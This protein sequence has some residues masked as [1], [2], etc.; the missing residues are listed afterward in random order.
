MSMR[1]EARCDV[2]IDT[3]R[4]SGNEGGGNEEGGSQK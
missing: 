2:G 4:S 1:R 3:N